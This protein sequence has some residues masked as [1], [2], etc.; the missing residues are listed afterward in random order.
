M[1]KIFIISALLFIGVA[2][3]AQTYT[4]LNDTT[5]RISYTVSDTVSLNYVK[6][7]IAYYNGVIDAS[8]ADKALAD[9]IIA[10]AKTKKDYWII[11]RDQLIA[12]GVKDR[13]GE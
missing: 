1:K 6:K 5:C 10:D 3:N 4:R 13:K 9:K 12:K 2:A 8:Q 7:Q 11:R